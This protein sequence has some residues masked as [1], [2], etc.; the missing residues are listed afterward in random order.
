MTVINSFWHGKIGKLET[1]TM[2]SF[3]SAG[4]IFRLWVYDDVPV[5]VGVSLENA[6]DIL[7]RSRLFTYTGNGD[8]TR[9]SIGGFSDIFRYHLLL[10][11]GGWYVDMDVCCL[12]NFEKLAAHDIVLRPHHKTGS[13]ANIIKIPKAHPILQSLINETELQVTANNNRWILPVEIFS[14]LTQTLNVKPAPVEWFGDDSPSQVES[15]IT[16]NYFTATLP[17]YAIHWCR[18]AVSTGQW[19]KHHTLNIQNPPELSVLYNLYQQHA[20]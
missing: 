9:G 16:Q 12:T 18:T 6:N 13:V 11:E 1:L 4:H 2:K 20:I 8:C 17:Q 19:H 15:L 3:V 10:R 5:P 14:R 7:P